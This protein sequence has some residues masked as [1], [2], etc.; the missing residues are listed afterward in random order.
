[1]VKQVRYW[2]SNR[3]TL[4][5]LSWEIIEGLD[6]SNEDEALRRY[7]AHLDERAKRAARLLS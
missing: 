6:P 3:A 1:M 7:K 5:M 4:R 2:F